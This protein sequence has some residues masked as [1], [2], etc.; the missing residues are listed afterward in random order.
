MVG[1]GE[2][3]AQR[4]C[5]AVPSSFDRDLVPGAKCEEATVL[6][7]DALDVLDEFV[8][9]ELLGL[10]LEPVEVDHDPVAP[11]VGLHEALGYGGVGRPVSG[12]R[13]FGS[14]GLRHR[15]KDK[16]NRCVA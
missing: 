8:E 2:N 7:A 10:L 1:V 14:S 16:G 3:V 4:V 5:A 15:G 12:Y 6:A 13:I 11:I 9:V